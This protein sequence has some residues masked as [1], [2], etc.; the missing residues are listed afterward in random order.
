MA[1]Y[2]QHEDCYPPGHSRGGPCGPNCPYN[3]APKRAPVHHLRKKKGET[4]CGRATSVALTVTTD[5]SA[6]T[7]TACRD[8]LNPGTY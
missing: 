2:G 7:C 4:S 3:S 5:K 1:N 8:V 6:V